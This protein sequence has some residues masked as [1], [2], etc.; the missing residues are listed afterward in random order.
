MGEQ[1][2]PSEGRSKPCELLP[3]EMTLRATVHPLRPGFIR[4]L[5][6][7]KD[8]TFGIS[9][10]GATLTDAAA[11]LFG[12]LERFGGIQKAVQMADD[13]A[14]AAGFIPIEPGGANRPL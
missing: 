9:G 14:R 2:Q 3:E 6:G 11:N 8:G 13:N 12:Y 10:E 4:L 7:S 5:L 1:N